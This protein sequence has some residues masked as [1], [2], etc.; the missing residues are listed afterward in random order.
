[1]K[2]LFGGGADIH[3][4]DRGGDTPLLHT[5]RGFNKKGAKLLID[6]GADVNV[7]NG[8]GETLLSIAVMESYT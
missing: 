2:L 8:R 5:V 3:C 7:R 1:M 4:R 6:L